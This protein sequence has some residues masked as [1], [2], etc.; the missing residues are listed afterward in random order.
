MSE[1]AD[2]GDDRI[3]SAVDYTLAAGVAVEILSTTDAFGTAAI[4]LTGNELN[5][6]IYGNLGNNTLSGGGGEDGLYGYDGND[7]L[8]GGA[9]ADD[10]L[11]GEGGNDQYLVDNAGDMVIEVAGQGTDRIYA[12]VSY[13]LAAGPRSRRCRPSIGPRPRRSTSPATSWPTPSTA[14]RGTTC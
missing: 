13:T 1:L 12:S 9:A 5:N 6:T 4:N 7:T 14:T 11:V 8:I 3:Y 2:E 10:L